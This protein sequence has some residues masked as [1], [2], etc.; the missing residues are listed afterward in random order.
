M[1]L[2]PAGPGE[3]GYSD[4]SVLLELICSTEE[5]GFTSSGSFG[6]LRSGRGW[7]MRRSVLAAYCGGAC[8]CDG[9]RGDRAGAHQAFCSLQAGRRVEVGSLKLGSESTFWP[10]QG[11]RR[12]ESTLLEGVEPR[13]A[14]CSRRK[15]RAG[16]V[17]APIRWRRGRDS[18][19]SSLRRPW[20]I[21]GVEDGCV[22]DLCSKD[23]VLSMHD[24][25]NRNVSSSSAR[26]KCSS[27]DE[28]RCLRFRDSGGVR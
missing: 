10:S 1:R 22:R 15:R 17:H 12:R 21:S 26:V 4:R 3:E 7:R 25:R 24:G 5:E 13:R 14:P 6:A 9:R 16:L 18:T 2:S 28:V 11:R 27:R 8:L 20:E 23:V 19:F